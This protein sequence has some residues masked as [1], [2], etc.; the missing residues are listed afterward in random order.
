MHAVTNYTQR[1]APTLLTHIPGQS[2][3]VENYIICVMF[4][5][6]LDQHLFPLEN[7]ATYSAVVCAYT[8]DVHDEP[9]LVFYSLR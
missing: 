1:P 3:R 7:L 8:F 5:H 4:S 6:I 2:V 9:L